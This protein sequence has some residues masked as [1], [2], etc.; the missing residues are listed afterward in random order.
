MIALEKELYAMSHRATDD[1]RR[2][3]LAF[4]ADLLT[5]ARACE[6]Y[7]LCRLR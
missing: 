1:E 6:L 7:R 5:E 2:L 3:R 4:A